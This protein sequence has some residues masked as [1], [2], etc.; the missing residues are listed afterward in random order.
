MP[1]EKAEESLYSDVPATDETVKAG[2]KKR[3][4]AVPRDIRSTHE[5][6]IIR[7]QFRKACAARRQSDGSY[8]DPCIHDGEPI[9]YSLQYPHP[10]SWSL[11]HVIPVS[12]RI[13][14]LLDP[15][16][17]ASAHFVC[18]SVNGNKGIESEIGVPSED[19]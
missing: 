9:D 11:E 4:D 13:E 2:Q 15:N 19:W 1:D 10:M 7:E 6:K 5:Y 14:L 8:G 17:F 12:D 3:N 18:N 16:N